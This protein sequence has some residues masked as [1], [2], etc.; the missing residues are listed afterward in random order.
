M[1]KN[2]D[3]SAS[4]NGKDFGSSDSGGRLPAARISTRRSKGVEK[5]S[6]RA[7]GRLL[8]ADADPSWPP[9]GIT[10]HITDTHHI[11]GSADLRAW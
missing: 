1:K 11:F 8:D 10:T 9:R 2:V 3:S 6:D 7:A 5:E 4:S